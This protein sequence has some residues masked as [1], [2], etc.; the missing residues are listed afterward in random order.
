MGYTWLMALMLKVLQGPLAGQSF[1]LVSG[2]QFGRKKGQIRLEDPKVSGTHAEVRLDQG[3][4]TLNDLGSKN[5]IRVG[6][7]RR[8]TLIL[9]AGLRFSIGESVFEVVLP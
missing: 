8:D 3:N 5:G 1:N 9:S 7:H 6:P 2:L 4:L